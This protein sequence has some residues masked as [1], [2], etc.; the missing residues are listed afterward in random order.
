[1]YVRFCFRILFCLV[2][3]LCGLQ[4][5]FL[6]AEADTAENS[7]D[8][9]GWYLGRRI[10][11]TMSAD[12]AEWLIRK[13][14]DREEQPKLLLKALQLKKGQVVCDF[15]CGNGFY[16]IPLAHRVGPLGRVI[17]LDIQQE[18]LD[19]LKQ[20]IEPR[21]IRNVETVLA[22]T[23]DPGIV[24]KSLDMVLMVDVYHELSDPPGILRNVK[25]GLKRE[26]LLVLV[27]YREEDPNVPIRPL[28]KM[29]QR[30]IVK[31]LRQNNFK[32]VRQFDEL[33]WQHVMFF[34]RCEAPLKEK[35][36]ELWRPKNAQKF[37]A[38]ASP[39]GELPPDLEESLDDFP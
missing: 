9:P 32:L 29:N 30:Q 25:K 34:A 37:R 22:T 35:E 31:E 19:L 8:R 1:M 5:S 17:A 7:L 18:M 23:E 3:C 2:S 12:G 27:E 10:A 11:P 14:R 24:P 33:P 15:G 36:I 16:T 20:R 39:P 28:H 38:S 13:S 21:G 6:R 4:P 26:G